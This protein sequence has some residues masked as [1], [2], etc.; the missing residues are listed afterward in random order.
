MNKETVL[1]CVGV[2]TLLTMIV[3]FVYLDWFFAHVNNEPADVEEEPAPSTWQ[4]CHDT[5]YS[6]AMDRANSLT[7]VPVIN[8][9]SELTVCDR[10]FPVMP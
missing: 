8:F 9:I 2:A 6:K 3:C 10:M 7:N 4:E 5:A 1:K